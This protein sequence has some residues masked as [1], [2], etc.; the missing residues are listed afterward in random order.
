MST[1]TYSFKSSGKTRE[2]LVQE[3]LKVSK[4]PFGIKTPLTLGSETGIFEMNYSLS[5]QFS[6]NLKNLLLTNWGEHLGI[7]D[8]G[9][10]LRPLTME[11]SSQE[12]FDTQAIERIRAAVSRWMPYVELNTFTS[13]VDRIEN[14]STAVIKITISYF[15]RG[16]DDTERSIQ[17]VF[18]CI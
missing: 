3:N 12:D 5:D 6:D 2:S 18:Y 16:I 13:N 7:H 1:T 14:K 15:I 10:N 9:A 4:V 8:F 17:I 11:F